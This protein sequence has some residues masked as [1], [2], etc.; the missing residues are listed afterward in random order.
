M[1]YILSGLKVTVD[2]RAMRPREPARPMPAAVLR[3]PELATRMLR[4]RSPTDPGGSQVHLARA[5]ALKLQQM[6]LEKQLA[7]TQAKTPTSPQMAVQIQRQAAVI[8]QQVKQ[9][10]AEANKAAMA[11]V[12]KG[13]P[14]AEVKE[15][16]SVNTSTSMTPVIESSTADL[17]LDGTVK[18]GPDAAVVTVPVTS[19]PGSSNTPAAAPAAG[20]AAPAA[21]AGGVPTIV[22]AGAAVGGL[23]LLFKLFGKK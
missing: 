7:C 19:D 18:M 15:A 21:G 8:V 5:K 6:A 23:Y 9:V 16:V 10:A 2:P 12:E 22:K 3:S 17:Q 11:A 20:A 13:A 14:P 1:T 4:P